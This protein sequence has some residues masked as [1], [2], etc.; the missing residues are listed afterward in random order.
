MYLAGIYITFLISYVFYINQQLH[1]GLWLK[2][3]LIL[4]RNR[5]R[6]RVKVRKFISPD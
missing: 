4:S 5:E 6:I 3:E 1:F 2:D